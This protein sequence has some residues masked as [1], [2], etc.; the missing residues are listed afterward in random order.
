MGVSDILFPLCSEILF[1]FFSP[2]EA[3]VTKIVNKSYI[4]FFVC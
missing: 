2:A 3:I 1:Y 4:I